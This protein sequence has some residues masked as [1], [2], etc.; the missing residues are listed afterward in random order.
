M[1]KDWM[2][3]EYFPACLFS[4]YFLLFCLCYELGREFMGVVM[5]IKPYVRCWETVPVKHFKQ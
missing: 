3:N 1:M 5:G 2:G 4:F